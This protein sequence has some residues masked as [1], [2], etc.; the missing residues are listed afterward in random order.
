MGATLAAGT[1]AGVIVAG[2]AF[3]DPG[4]QAHAS[5][6]PL[7]QSQSEPEPEPEPEPVLFPPPPPAAAPAEPAPIWSGTFLDQPDAQLLAP[8]RHGEIR[9]VRFN[10]GGSS[11]SLRI[12]FQ[13]GARAAFKPDQ[14]NLQ[15]IPRKEVAAYRL[16]RLVGLEAVP[17]AIARAFPRAAI[18]AALEPAARAGLPRL[19]EEA[20][21][22]P[23]GA[24]RG[25]LSYWIPVIVD[26]KVG[27]LA[28]DS[29]EGMTLWQRALVVGQAIPPEAEVLAPQ[30]SSM[31]AFDFLINN[32]DRWSG[33]N[34]KTSP[35]G[36][37]LFYMDNTLSFGEKKRAH[38]RVAG[39]LERVQRFSRRL[40]EGL[41]GLQRDAIERAVTTDTGPYPRLLSEAEVEAVLW[42]RDKILGHV[43]ALV[44]AHGDAEVLCFP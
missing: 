24:I 29:A 42:R 8:L 43:D 44:A 36:G 31:L 37:V 11:L 5:V 38:T 21:V 26:A 2:R 22:G 28:V 13:D 19:K 15:T 10:R 23:D 33:S 41:R 39:H 40:I 12:E 35:D 20:I 32:A 7:P 4:A 1:A 18:L 3:F 27:P 25:E 17:P 14:T 9:R 30:I 34:V 6:I 16:S